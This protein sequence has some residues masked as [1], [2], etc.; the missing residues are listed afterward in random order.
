[1]TEPHLFFVEGGALAVENALK[2]A[3]DWK[4]RRNEA[5][6]LGV[7]VLH[8]TRAFHGRS[9]YTLSLTNTEPGKTDRFPQVRLAQD[10]RARGPVPAGG[11]P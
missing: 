8:L 2:T 10:R 7:K 5:A 4:S 11:P 3:F 6:G 1:M 9:G